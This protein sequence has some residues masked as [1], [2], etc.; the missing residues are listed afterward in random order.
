MSADCV[1]S[2]SSRLFGV[3]Q[4]ID[5]SFLYYTVPLH[6]LILGDESASY[7]YRGR[8]DYSFQDESDSATPR[9]ASEMVKD[10]L[11]KKEC[12]DVLDLG[13]GS[14]EF[15]EVLKKEY[16]PKVRV[17]GIT[18]A[19]F[20]ALEQKGFSLSDEEYII[21]NLENLEKIEAVRCR[22]FDL[23]VASF[24]FRHLV[25]PIGV[26]C[27]CYDLLTPGGVLISD[28]FCVFGVDFFAFK[29]L[30]RDYEVQIVGDSAEG[31]ALV[32]DFKIIKTVSSLRLALYYDLGKSTSVSVEKRER[33]R[34]HYCTPLSFCLE[35]QPEKEGERSLFLKV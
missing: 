13:T 3:Q 1:V 2:S 30:F 10:F 11:T 21:G 24:T 28:Y 34:L 31:V 16:G 6:K 25:D 18:A 5:D 4:L 27:R 26:I 14:G 15:L 32:W 9:L 7:K 17:M 12:L 8:D 22:Q 23:I 35:P 20:R 29:S 19:D 33:A